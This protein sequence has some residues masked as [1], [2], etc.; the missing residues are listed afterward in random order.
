MHM[1]SLVLTSIKC[2]NVNHVYVPSRVEY[3]VPVWWQIFYSGGFIIYIVVI[4]IFSN[5]LLICL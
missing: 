5:N 2:K 3:F 4:V 1:C